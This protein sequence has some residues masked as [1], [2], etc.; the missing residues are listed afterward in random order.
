M[1]FE[2]VYSWSKNETKTQFYFYLCG[3]RHDLES[4]IRLLP[5]LK[6]QTPLI[7]PNGTGD[8]S[9]CSVTAVVE[10]HNRERMM[11]CLAALDFVLDA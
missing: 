2:R 11:R 7:A 1:T 3:G 4:I 5:I 6:L 9:S 8:A 10:P